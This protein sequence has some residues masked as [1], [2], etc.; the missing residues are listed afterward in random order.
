MVI[1]YMRDF[2]TCSWR[3][4]NSRG[5]VRAGNQETLP[6]LET[7]LMEAVEMAGEDAYCVAQ[8]EISLLDELCFED[9]EEIIIDV[10]NEV[11]GN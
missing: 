2:C 5:L 11:A 6:G 9:D 8:Y 10:D 4:Q 7:I 3:V 1:T